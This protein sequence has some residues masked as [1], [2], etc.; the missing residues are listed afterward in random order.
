MQVTFTCIPLAMTLVMMPSP[1]Y[2]TITSFWTVCIKPEAR[3]LC[4]DIGMVHISQ[5]NA[6][7]F[8]NLSLDIGDVPIF[9][10]GLGIRLHVSS[11]YFEFLLKSRYWCSLL[12]RGR[13][14]FVVDT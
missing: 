12:R 6:Y 2:H 9:F 11:W 5:F 4:V 1:S 10:I 3:R 7:S 13:Q 14:I 8:G